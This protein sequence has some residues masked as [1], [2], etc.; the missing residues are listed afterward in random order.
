MS[1]GGQHTD[2]LIK[3]LLQVCD[4]PHFEEMAATSS[5]GERSQI[6]LIDLCPD[7]EN[8]NVWNRMKVNG[9]DKCVKCKSKLLLIDWRLS[10]MVTDA[11]TQIFLSRVDAGLLVDNGVH[12]NQV[13]Y[14]RHRGKR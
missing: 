6:R 3:G 14:F 1:V 11:F 13:L 4:V 5:C 9:L 7:T 2:D 8:I 12:V 10:R